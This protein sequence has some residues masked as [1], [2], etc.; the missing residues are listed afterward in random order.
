MKGS[1]S[2]NLII[3]LVSFSIYLL[4]SSLYFVSVSHAQEMLESSWTKGTPIPT[5][6]TEVTSA[7]LEDAVYVIGGFTSDGVTTAIVEMY[8]ATS[9][10]W[11]TDIAPLP[12]L[13]IMLYRSLFK[14]GSM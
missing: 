11:K 2:R 6:R 13:F 8:N 4:V 14:T 12:V 9:D 1:L 3:T 7:N 5:P 10:S